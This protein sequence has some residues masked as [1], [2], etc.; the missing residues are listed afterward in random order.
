MKKPSKTVITLF[1]VLVFL[2]AAPAFAG[3]TGSSI[4]YGGYQKN[5]KCGRYGAKAVIKTADE[6]RQVIEGFLAGNNLRIGAMEERPN[7][8]IVKLVDGNGAVQDVV[9]VNKGNGR[10]RSTY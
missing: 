2:I 3:Q 7:F 4:P 6:A 1:A 8:F 5:G 10:V 9:I